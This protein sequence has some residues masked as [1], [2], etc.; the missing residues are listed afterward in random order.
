M[1]ETFQAEDRSIWRKWL[2]SNFQTQREVWLIFPNKL[3]GIKS[4]SYND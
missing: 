4:V 3:S 1:I 2:E